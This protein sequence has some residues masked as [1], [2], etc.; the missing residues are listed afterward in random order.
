MKRLS[1]ITLL[2]ISATCILS[3]CALRITSSTTRTIQ[4]LEEPMMADIDVKSEKVTGTYTERKR[5]DEKR[6]KLNAVY[7]A[8]A[9]GT[10]GDILVAPQ[11]EIVKDVKMN[12]AKI[13]SVTV[14]VTGYPAFYKNFRPVPKAAEYEIR[15]V[16]PQTPFVII[17]KD[18]DGNPITYEV[19]DP[20]YPEPGINMGSVESIKINPN[21][22][23]SEPANTTTGKGKKK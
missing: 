1:T 13:K 10:K 7:N 8:L 11:Y 2:L 20:I 18:N 14:T 15:E 19:K 5:A 6:I 22:P 16:T 9:N 4:P 23:T 17:T 21:E 12:G 3:S